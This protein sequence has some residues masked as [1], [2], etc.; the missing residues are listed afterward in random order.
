MLIMI[1]IV[2]C[3]GGWVCVIVCGVGGGWG[4]V[5]VGGGVC[6][7]VFRSVLRPATVGSLLFVKWYKTAIQDN[8]LW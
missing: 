4:C 2:L 1:P 3:V 6:G 5:Y 7:D 8:T